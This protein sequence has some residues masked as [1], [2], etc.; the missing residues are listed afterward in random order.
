FDPACLELAAGFAG[1]DRLL[2]G[3]DYPH[4]IGSM[5]KM[6]ESVGRIGVTE[7]DRAGILG[8]NARALLGF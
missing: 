2:A 1:P 6:V 8:G 4:M 3:S 5:E 7:E